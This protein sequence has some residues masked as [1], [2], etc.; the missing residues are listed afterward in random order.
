M[1][2]TD[3]IKQ[4]LVILDGGLGTL[5]QKKGLKAGELPE[6][7]NLSHPEILTAVHKAYFDAGSN[8]VNANTFGAN[9]L[10]F[11][12]NEL[13]S[14][15]KAAIDNAKEAAKQSIS[16]SKKFI[17]LDMGPTGK[18]LSPLGSIAFEEAVNIFAKTVRLGAK[19]GADLIMIETMTDLY[20][21]KAALLAAK[22]NCDLPVFVSNAYS[23]NGRLLTGAEPKAVIAVLEG[24]GADAIGVNCS[25]GPADLMPVIKDYLKYSS[26]PL[27]FKPNAGLPSSVNGETVYDVSED[28]FSETMKEAANLGVNIL[29]GCC[30][31][32]PE[33]ISALY[34]SVKD[35]SPTK[36]SKKSFTVVSSY[37]KAQV[38]S[39]SPL[40]IGERINPTGKKRFK[41][42]LKDHDIDHI[43]DEALKQEDKGVH[44]LDVNVGTPEINEK[45]LLPEV[46][47]EIQT[48]TDIPLQID[49]SNI[50]ALENAMRIY[51]GKAM[52]NSVNGKKESMNAVFPLMKKYGA[53]AV[54]L[55]L[56]ESGI[57]E[58]AE[59]RLE[60]AK[61]ILNEAESYGIDKKDIVFD[62]LCMAV[63]AQPN[64]AEIT[65]DALK[66]IKDNLGCK[67]VLGISNISFGL[68]NREALNASFFTLA[69]ENGLSAAIINPYS[70]DMMKAYYSF[71]ALKG[72]DESF[73]EYIKKAPEL[74]TEAS[75]HLSAE[76][77]APTGT[78]LQKA[79][80]SGQ[81][82]RA[83]EITKKLSENNEPLKLISD[84]IIPALNFVGDGFESKKLY[85]PQLLM[86]AEAAGAAFEVI[87]AKGALTEEKHKN[88]HKIVL[89]TVKGDIHDIGK[90]I[91]KL[92]LENYG[93]SV[94][95]LGK[96]VAPEKIAD[97]VIREN[98][99][100]AGLSALMTTTVPAMKETVT[101]LKEKA[102]D[103]RVIVGGAVLT[104]EYAKEIGAHYYSKDAISTVRIADELT[105]K[106]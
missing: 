56:D 9:C 77:D 95:D 100:I 8:T 85:L 51:N 41:Q 50:Y 37:S 30:G 46:I 22:E 64:A 84:E 13:E 75:K 101:L 4:S 2:I 104:E 70:A 86:S 54:A 35:I 21:T 10:K 48:V 3:L 31:T 82:G 23:E 72:N 62:P 87:K 40:L 80:I 52:I 11:S 29:G 90:N 33:Y 27:I 61:K 59:G 65:L 28:E 99:Y 15:I 16:P 89:A 76:A 66:L 97:T 7:W 49:S 69:C 60:I 47:Y 57:P 105:K 19:H 55:T 18:M 58:T 5:L 63:S 42:A 44:L 91:V 45:K 32:T 12:E 73:S 38:F 83:A 92:L 34:N 39:N 26:L 17:A 88:G 14:I 1:L 102:P 53:V 96:D 106:D 43:L 103:C 79:I 20:E 67:T 36:I 93:Y 6:K 78:E 94:I 81:K 24:M 71:N 98:A 25:L 68:P 74:I